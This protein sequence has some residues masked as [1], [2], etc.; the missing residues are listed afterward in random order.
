MKDTIIQNIK[1]DVIELFNDVIKVIILNKKKEKRSS[2]SSSQL[3]LFCLQ[4]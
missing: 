1:V 4:G 2:S 3:Q